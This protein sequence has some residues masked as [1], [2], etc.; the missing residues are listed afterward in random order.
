MAK[1]NTTPWVVAGGKQG[2]IGHCERCGVG[3]E[4]NM[5]QPLLIVTAAMKAFT[6]IHK[7]CRDTGR[8]EPRPMSPTEWRNGRDTG[9]SSLTIYS[10]VT[11]FPSPHECYNPPRDP[12]D[13]GRCYR[14]LKLFPDWLKSMPAV[15]DRYPAWKPFVREWEKLTTMYEKALATDDGNVMYYFMQ[16]LWD[17]KLIA[18]SAHVLE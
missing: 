17:E 2:E 11:G 13:F 14:L 10:V 7:G 8:T 1:P 3:L 6:T 18:E 5:P 4:L 9:I 12:S 15:A 16:Q